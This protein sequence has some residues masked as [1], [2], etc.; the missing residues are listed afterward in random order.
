MQCRGH[1]HTPASIWSA[2][3]VRKEILAVFRS[4]DYINC[5][6]LI[7]IHCD[8]SFRNLLL[9]GGS[10]KSYKQKADT[11]EMEKAATYSDFK[12]CSGR[13][14]SEYKEKNT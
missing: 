6:A 2:E 14:L 11:H 4:I 3:T 8:C 13:R 12:L 9:H 7:F 10:E 1:F 5:Y